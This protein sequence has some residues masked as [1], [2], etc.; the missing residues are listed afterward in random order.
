MQLHVKVAVL[1]GGLD[2]LAQILAEQ[3]LV[4]QEALAHALQLA[5]AERDLPVEYM[6]LCLV[7]PGGEGKH[8]LEGEAPGQGQGDGPIGAVLAA[9][10]RRQR[11][12]YPVGHPVEKV[13]ALEVFDGLEDGEAADADNLAL[14]V[15]VGA[16]AA[17][18]DQG[19]SQGGAAD[20]DGQVLAE[21]VARRELVA[22]RG[23]HALDVGLQTL[24]ELALEAGRQVDEAV[25]ADG[26]EQGGLGVL[27]EVVE[28]P[29][30][31]AAGEG[32]GAGAMG[33]RQ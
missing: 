21:L 26:A 31:L 15:P 5:A 16:P 25:A 18:L 14:P 24:Q 29:G 19:D 27:E 30:R 23:Q 10:V 17:Q 11:V 4:G 6:S 7:V 32:R 1:A 9:E 28:A 8:S 12:A 3:A 2:D 33:P 20:V 13:H 22:V